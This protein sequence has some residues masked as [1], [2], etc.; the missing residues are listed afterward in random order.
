MDSHFLFFQGLGIPCPM[1]PFSSVWWQACVRTP[2]T[3]EK[4]EKNDHVFPDPRTFGHRVPHL[5]SSLSC[6]AALVPSHH[7]HDLLHG[8]GAPP[9]E[10]W[11]SCFSSHPASMLSVM[12][13]HIWP[14]CVPSRMKIPSAALGLPS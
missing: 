14:T 4:N 2:A 6:P 1:P 12:H 8:G 13:P 11:V 9:L 5:P 3:Q 10:Q 7:Y